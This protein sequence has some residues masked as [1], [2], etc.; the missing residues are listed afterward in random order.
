MTECIN[1]YKKD[2]IDLP[3]SYTWRGHGSAIFIELGKLTKNEKRNHP[4][5]EYSLMLDCDWRI[6]NSS[7]IECGSFCDQEQIEASIL[8][9]L[10]N[11]ISNI[12]LIGSLAEISISLSSG[13]KLLSFTSDVGNP[14]WAI[15][16]P[17]K[18]WLCSKGGSLVREKA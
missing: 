17:D 8:D 11:K 1:S 10:E 4:N 13:Q 12:E 9:L 14:E 15:F 5:G 18:S 3:V 16:L 6:E 2:I 7:E